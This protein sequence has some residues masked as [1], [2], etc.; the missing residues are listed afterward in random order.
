MRDEHVDSIDIWAD[1]ADDKAKEPMRT[2]ARAQPL[3]LQG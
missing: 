2:L 1:A 3:P